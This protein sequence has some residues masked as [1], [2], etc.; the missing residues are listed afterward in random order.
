MIDPL[1]QYELSKGHMQD[2]LRR[3]V[4]QGRP[5]RLEGA[6]RRLSV[7]GRDDAQPPTERGMEAEAC[8]ACANAAMG[9]Y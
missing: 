6:V 1:M 8:S 9:T 4:N 7:V 3:A 5:G 2:I